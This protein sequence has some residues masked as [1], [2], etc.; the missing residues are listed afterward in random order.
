M[1]TI[2]DRTYLGAAW[3]AAFVILAIAALISAQ[4][5]L[6]FL[7][8]VFGLPLP[9]TIPSYA[10]FSG[11]MLAAATFLAMPY[12]FRSGGHIKVS[13]VTAR[14]PTRGQFWA[15]LVAL[16]VGAFLV[17]YACVY[18]VALVYESWHFN[19][20]SPGIIPIPLWIP[21]CFMALGMILLLLSV[22]DS[23]AQTWRRGAPVIQNAEEV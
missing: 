10:D 17:G 20:L 9:S 7:T 14:L 19:D 16:A 11:F 8:R 13:L 6:N 21:Q 3:I 15:E 4:V 18:I 5:S 2:L 1:R 22:L 12:T 23:L